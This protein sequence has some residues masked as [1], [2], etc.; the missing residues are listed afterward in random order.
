MSAL[1][2]P[3]PDDPA[4]ARAG[5]R[6]R[7]TSPRTSAA[8]TRSVSIASEIDEQT[9]LGEVYISSLM[10]SQLR[11]AVV[12]LAVLASTL[13]L[14]PLVLRAVPAVAEV[15]LLGVPLPWLLLTV[16]AF[17]EIILLGWFYVRR[18]ERNE[19]DF[20]DLLAGR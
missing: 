18:S 7:V 2:R 1:D 3:V 8:R 16:A 12:V 13:G 17:S 20:S 10:R 5:A 11:L 4:G 15:R 9:R 19:A 14:L 6:V